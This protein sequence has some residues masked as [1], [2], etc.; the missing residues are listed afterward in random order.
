MKSDN[1][2]GLTFCLTGAMSKPRNLIQ[3]DI[4]EAGGQCKSGVTKDLS[5]LVQADV[6]SKSSKS[7]K[8][9][10]LGVQIINELK[11]YQL[12]DGKL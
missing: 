2:I 5:F 7:E 12:I 10:K 11:L 3:I 1:L 8:A 4:E 9:K 6:D